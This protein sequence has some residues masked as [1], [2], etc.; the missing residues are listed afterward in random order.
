MAMPIRQ[1]VGASQP[2]P[3]RLENMMYCP[4]CGQTWPAT[5]LVDHLWED[6]R[7]ETASLAAQ[8]KAKEQR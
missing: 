1:S 8:I 3:T 5:H 2:N 4:I 7:E 6:H